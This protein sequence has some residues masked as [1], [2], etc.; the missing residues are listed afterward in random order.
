MERNQFFHRY[1]SRTLRGFL[2]TCCSFSK[3]LGHLYLTTPPNGCYRSIGEIKL[4]VGHFEI[5]ASALVSG[6]VFEYRRSLLQ[7]M[8]RLQQGFSSL[9][10][11]LENDYS[12]AA[13]KIFIKLLIG[14]FF[15]PL[16]A[17]PQNGQN[18]LK[19]F[20]KCCRLIV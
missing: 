1:S 2:A 15:N 16:S 11:S 7:I 19:Q 4:Q 9:C 10:V 13:N 6:P 5:Q 3:F 20:V 18:A 17:N 14:D 12:Q 8:N